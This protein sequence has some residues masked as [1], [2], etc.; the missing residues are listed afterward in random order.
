MDAAGRA[1]TYAL[2]HVLEL[3]Q[4]GFALSNACP[5]AAG[6]AP[7]RAACIAADD[8]CRGVMSILMRS[9]SLRD[10][11][12]PSM[13]PSVLSGCI[14]G[15][16]GVLSPLESIIAAAGGN[17]S[18]IAAAAVPLMT[19]LCDQLRHLSMLCSAPSPAPS[20]PPPLRAHGLERSHSSPALPPSPHAHTSHAPYTH[21]SSLGAHAS[22]SSSP[23]AHALSPSNAS[24][25]LDP[26]VMH[27][28]IGALWLRWYGAHASLQWHEF[29]VRTHALMPLTEH[30]AV[31]LRTYGAILHTPAHTEIVTIES[32]A[33]FIAT[34]ASPSG[35][36][37]TAWRSYWAAS[38]TGRSDSADRG[39]VPAQWWDALTEGDM[40]DSVRACLAGVA[41][42]AWAGFA[43]RA[44]VESALAATGPGTYI[45]RLSSTRA[46][47][48]ALSYIPRG[49]SPSSV[50]HEIVH[51]SP[52]VDGFLFRG[53][54][55]THMPALLS[56]ESATLTFPC[57]LAAANAAAA[58]AGCPAFHGII[59][60]EATIARLT[61]TPAGAYLLRYSQS[62]RGSIVCAYMC[63]DG[64]VAQSLIHPA[65]PP[66]TPSLTASSSGGT[67]TQGESGVSADTSTAAVIC[68]GRVYSTLRAALIAHSGPGGILHMEIPAR[69]MSVALRAGVEGAARA[70][71]R[72]WMQ[73]SGRDDGPMN[74]MRTM[75]ATPRGDEPSLPAAAGEDDPMPA[76]MSAGVARADSVA[77]STGSTG[78]MEALHAAHALRAVSDGTAPFTQMHARGPSSGTGSSSGHIPQASMFSMVMAGAA[79]SSNNSVSMVSTSMTVLAT[80]ASSGASGGTGGGVKRSNESTAAA[81]SADSDMTGSVGVSTHTLTAGSSDPTV[82]V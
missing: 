12:A 74:E 81:A 47:T 60:Y 66:G 29:A 2:A 73:A 18:L 42:G 56:A 65:P 15:I 80:S 27:S 68:S 77:S 49:S 40:C 71:A 19:S 46:C 61:H 72:E 69:D 25:A 28:P 78:S 70:R 62:T 26:R 76:M 30:H 44:D 34:F 11:A 3:C 50:V 48:I 32:V 41:P 33:R 7:L 59:S 57:V 35:V 51:T 52:S 67:R 38:S 79:G 54:T 23:L 55:Y 45:L 24:V 4:R 36:H 16:T 10:A 14:A 21:A 5:D 58:G 37:A 43:S 8:V 13:D 75:S 20:P 63:A 6:S 82:Q 31:N 22:P 53:R 39:S 17:P 64:R 1:P 9:S